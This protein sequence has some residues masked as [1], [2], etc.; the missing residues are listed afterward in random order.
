MDF[1]KT[2]LTY[3]AITV[4]LSVQEGPLPEDVP[5]PTPLPPNV[6]A[7]LEPNTTATPTL[8]PTATPVPEPTIT[9]NLSYKTVQWKDRGTNVKKVQ[10]RLIELGYL[11]EGEDDGAF[12]AKTASAVRRF[13]RANGLNVDGVAGQVTQTRLFED[14]NVVPAPTATPVLT[15]TPV[16]A[17]D[18]PA[19]VEAPDAQAAATADELPIPV[20]TAQTDPAPEGL[21]TLEGGTI[22]LGN[23]GSVLTMTVISDGVGYTRRPSLFLN[24]EHT[25][26][27]RLSELA[28]CIGDW[29]FTTDGGTQTL[30]AAGYTVVISTAD[31]LSVT[32][33]GTP[34]T[35]SGGELLFDNGEAYIS[36]SF[37]RAT[38][39]ATTV[40]DQDENSLIL[41]IQNKS[42][43]NS[44]D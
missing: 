5:T 19:P 18:T 3:V 33:D 29:T 27:M 25:P 39:S 28:A 4:A 41:F 10:K 34:V 8:A 36:D 26:F 11:A 30:T 6:T 13:Q 44:V 43:N 1:L 40:F 17:T 16:P 23:S 21:T 7:T 14:E 2:L 15:A 31:S 24:A 35:L 38:L 20:T 9:P 12:G 37:L 22:I 42:V 32:V